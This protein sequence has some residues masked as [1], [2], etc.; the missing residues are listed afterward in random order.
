MTA[1]CPSSILACGMRVTLLDSLGNVSP[2]ANNFWVSDDLI[3]ITT[4]PELAT[5]SDR[6]LRSGCDCV[7]AS[8]KFPDLLKRFTFEIQKGQLQPGLEALMLGEDVIL[9]GADPIGAWFANNSECGAA[10]IPNVALEVWSQAY[11]GNGQSQTLPFIHW[12]WPLTRWQLGA[13][14]LSS[15]FKQTVLTGFSDPNTR[16]GHGPYNDDPGEVVGPL[17]GYWFTATAPPAAECAYQTVSP[18]S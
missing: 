18:S 17:G 3:Q 2:D 12:I 14:T 15:D 4:T 10:P 1:I 6:E 9:D 11:E 16:W 8:A 5:G 13:S 7:I